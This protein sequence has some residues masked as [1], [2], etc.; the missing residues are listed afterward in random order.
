[1]A[2]A[3][4]A[5]L[6]QAPAVFTYNNPSKQIFP[7]G[8]KTSGQFD[9]EYNQ[10]KPYDEFPVTIKGPTV[11][12][13]GDYAK[14]PEQ[15]THHFSAEEVKEMSD[16]ADAFIASDTPLTGISKVKRRSWWFES[17]H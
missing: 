3:A 7:D 15:W 10:I 16:A 12:E 14:N 1:M 17:T 11:W 8:I 13:A 6:A 4:I 2:P 9:P 5:D